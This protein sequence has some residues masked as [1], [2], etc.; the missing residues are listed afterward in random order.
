[1][2]GPKHVRDAMANLAKN[3]HQHVESYKKEKQA[4]FAQGQTTELQKELESI[5][6][7]LDLYY[8]DN[9]SRVCDTAE[10]IAFQQQKI[11]I[12]QQILSKN[13]GNE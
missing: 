8:S 3:F 2:V 7:Y 12:L 6:G 13:S 9:G 11:S 5:H 10:N 1:M 4:Q